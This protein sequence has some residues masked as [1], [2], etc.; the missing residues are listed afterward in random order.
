MSAFSAASA[1]SKEGDGQYGAVLSPQWA[2]GD[3]PHGGYLLAVVARAALD[4]GAC[5]AGDLAP[6]P[7]VVSAQFL[8]PPSC[9]P[10]LIRTSVL[11]TGRT[12]TVVHAVLEQDGQPCVDAT[13]TCGVLP[14]GAASWL[15]VPPLPASPP[16]DAIDISAH[17][18]NVFKLANACRM[19][20]DAATAGFATGRTGLP[21]RVRVWV[22]PAGEPPDPLFAL[23]AGD[24]SPPVVFNLGHRGWS[25]TVQL[26]A[27]LRARPAPGW[28]RVQA[29]ARAV[30]GPWF[31]EDHTVIDSSGALICQTRQLAMA[32]RS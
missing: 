14:D 18:R 7:L 4:A 31:D 10:A 15:D 32:P 17:P 3:R 27:L 5:V 22:Q 16:A 12:V 28:L 2:V 24:V 1:V 11:R 29:E 20:L 23:V 9:A 25:P 30:H 6:D 26:T 19:R 21:P 8:R 13:V